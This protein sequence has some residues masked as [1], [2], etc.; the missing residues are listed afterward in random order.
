[1]KN[2]GMIIAAALRAAVWKATPVRGSAP[3]HVVV[4]WAIV[5]IAAELTQQYFQ[6]RN[7]GYFNPYGLNSTLAIMAIAAA[8]VL[9]F[10]SAH[11]TLVLATVFALTRC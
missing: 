5:A 4:T 11:R 6:S 1:M 10:T 3:I 2:H 7:S 9:L 8:V